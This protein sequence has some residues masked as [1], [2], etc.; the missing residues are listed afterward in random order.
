MNSIP[1][2]SEVLIL[3]ILNHQT[4]RFLPNSF[5]RAV[6]DDLYTYDIAAAEWMNLSAVTVGPVPPP[7]YT[8][9]FAGQDGRLILFGG[10]GL[11]G[12]STRWRVRGGAAR[13]V[14]CLDAPRRRTRI[15][16]P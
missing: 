11:E 13:P 12:K 7:R 6:F 2:F 1:I 5:V 16:Q 14:S 3:G 9:A 10:Y 8:Q 15:C 4:V